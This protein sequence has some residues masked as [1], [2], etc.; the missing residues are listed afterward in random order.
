L[1]A[2]DVRRRRLR[3]LVSLSP[4]GEVPDVPSPPPDFEG[5]QALLALQRKLERMPARVG[6]GYGLHHIA[7]FE[8]P[9]VART[10][11]VSC[12]TAKRAV[13]R[14]R[15]RLVSLERLADS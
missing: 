2:S 8:L 6:L 11:G 1:A 15:E 4:T 13:A 14:A 10:L 5:R 3:R 9:D 12:S 7:G